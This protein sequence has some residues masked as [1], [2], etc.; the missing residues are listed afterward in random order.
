MSTP[1]SVL[2]SWILHRFL[3]RPYTF[4]ILS[5]LQLYSATLHRKS[6]ELGSASE[7]TD[8]DPFCGL[9]GCWMSSSAVRRSSTNIKAQDSFFL[10]LAWRSLS[11]KRWMLASSVWGEFLENAIFSRRDCAV[12]KC[13]VTFEQLFVGNLEVT[14]EEA[15]STYLKRYYGGDCIA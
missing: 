11:S 5:N 4:L 13:C 8:D 12:K 3:T 15:Y 1:R 9:E 14:K 2:H 6:A 10:L 7:A